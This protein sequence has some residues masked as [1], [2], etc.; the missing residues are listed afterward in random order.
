M[1]GKSEAVGGVDSESFSI[2]LLFMSLRMPAVHNHTQLLGHMDTQWK[3]NGTTTTQRTCLERT[4][5]DVMMQSVIP[6]V[7][8][9]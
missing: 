4:R 9:V 6:S 7:T 2:K 5:C 8:V 1:M 3:L